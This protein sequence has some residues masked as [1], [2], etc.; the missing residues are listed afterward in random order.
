MGTPLFIY[1][2]DVGSTVH[3]N[4]GWARLSP[5]GE[6][7]TGSEMQVVAQKLGEDLLVG[8]VALGV[9]CPLFVPLRPEPLE[10]LRCRPGEGT[11]S[12]SASAGI[13]ALGMGIVQGAWLLRELRKLC[14]EDIPAFLTPS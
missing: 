13:T 1:C 2:V 3:G 5:A 14:R 9:E 10:L 8:R 12:W 7:T 6:L 11:R 4:F